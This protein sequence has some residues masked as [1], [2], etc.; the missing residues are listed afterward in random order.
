M[1]VRCQDFNAAFSK[2][3]KAKTGVEVIISQSHG[4]S[5]IRWGRLACTARHAA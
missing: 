3:W 4:G 5:G 1:R 2:Y